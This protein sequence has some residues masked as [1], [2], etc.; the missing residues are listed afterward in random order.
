MGELVATLTLDDSKFQA[1]LKN[2]MDGLKA[3]TWGKAADQAGDAASDNLT[4]DSGKFE[5]DAEQA[6]GSLNASEFGAAADQ[7]SA[8]ASSGLTLDDAKFA[9]D[10]D[11]AADQL[12][13]S[14]FRA[15]AGEASAAASSAL[16]LDSGKFAGDANAAADEISPSK[17]RGAA[18]GASNAASSALT[19][20]DSKFSGDAK[21]AMEALSSTEWKAAGTAAG[22]AAAAGLGIGMTSAINVDGAVNK[23][24]ARLQLTEA[25]S[26]RVGKVAGGL[27]ADGYG[28]SIDDITG[29]VSAVIS[30][31]EGMR[32]ASESEL[33]KVTEAALG[34]AETFDIDVSRAAQVAGQMMR[35]GLAPDAQ[36]AFDMIAQGAAN[37][38]DGLEGD[39]LDALD[40]Y[41]PYFEQLGLSG[42]SAMSMLVKGSEKGMYGIDKTGDAL[43][44]L[45]LRMVESDTTASETLGSM[46]LSMDTLADD[47]AVGGERGRSAMNEVI[48]GLLGIQDPGKRASAAIDLFGAPLE[49]MSTADI[50][51]F[52][53]TLKTGGDG[54]GDFSGA[55]TKAGQELNSGLG[56][57]LEQVKRSFVQQLGGIG[58]AIL[59]MIQPVLDTLKQFMPV[60]APLTL[61]VGGFGLAVLGINAAMAAWTAI[62]TAWTVVTKAATIAQKALNIAMRMNPIGI[63][64]TLIAAL[65]AGLIWFFTQTETGKAIWQGF[66]DWLVTA[67][68]WIKTTAVTVFNGIVNTI[69]GAW[70]WIKTTTSEVW[71]TIVTWVK[72]NWQSILDWLSLLN[73]VTAVIRHWDKI[74]AATGAAWDWVTNKL[75]GVWQ[76]IITWIATSVTKVWNKV[77]DGWNKVKSTTSSVWNA[78]KT[79]ISNVF[80]SVVRNVQARVNFIKSSMQ[81]AWARVKSVTSS[82]WNGI[83]TAVS[84][85]ITGAVNFVRQ[86]PGR[87][88][89]AL[90]NIGSKLYNSGWSMIQGFKDGI[91]SAFNNAVNAV[92][93]GLQR[94]RNFFPFSPAKEGPFS[95]KGW[96]FY[97][98]QSMSEGLA[99]GIASREADVA[100]QT[101]AIMKAAAFS[102]PDVG[103]DATG[104]KDRASQSSLDPS[105]NITFNITNPVAEPTSETARKASAYIGVSV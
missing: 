43:K 101:E 34:V 27:F 84:N 83:K 90:G 94:I 38:S 8:A 21:S 17:F 50:P 99:A 100:R 49:D 93:N 14:E 60:I 19:L 79:A 75:K 12:N 74:K 69:T 41:G 4:L 25:E 9:A 51:K 64:I 67:W 59:P 54:L 6:Q 47:M 28:E 62:T 20:D 26:A 92:R 89:S 88:L 30:S 85:G 29:S 66:V 22:A 82:A 53:Q 23:V 2:A 102:A 68:E 52:L 87:A 103:I 13:S 33:S 48:D 65:V 5:A 16:T 80:T 70:N 91:V 96:T 32:G 104:R 7:A 40:E 55:A 95:G 3:A 42:E 77:K 45:S 56:S 46:G 105:S 76:G 44:E 58:Q 37:V 73:P 35:Q 57:Q 39:L 81:N 97:S 61:A 31:M 78:I 24:S 36:S 86:L 71:N 63:I 98:G 10:A 11:V 1:T 18:K 72:D 15:A